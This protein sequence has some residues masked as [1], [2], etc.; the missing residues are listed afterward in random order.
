MNIHL[1]ALF[2]YKIFLY[3]FT[4]RKPPGVG[5]GRGRGRDD[6]AAGRPAKGIGRGVDDGGAKGRGK[7][8]S[9]GKA[10][11]KGINPRQSILG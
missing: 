8:F 6:G 7:G 3:G 2:I 1:V 11:G 10:S 4:D 5:R 9:S